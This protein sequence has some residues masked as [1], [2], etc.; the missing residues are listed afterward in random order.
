[1]P[2][3][4]RGRVAHMTQEA[5]SKPGALTR[6]GF[7]GVAA[8]AAGGVFWPHRAVIA[9]SNDLRMPP[10]R[11]PSRAVQMHSEE[12]VVGRAVHK[13][14]V[15]EMF[16]RSL[17]ALTDKREMAS[18]WR[19]ILRPDD[20]VGLKFN[21]SGQRNLGTS[22]VMGE[23]LI[24][25]LVDAGWPAEKL[26]CLEAPA[27]LETTA[28]TTVAVR[29]FRPEPTDFGSGRDQLARFV[30]QVTAIINVPFLKTHNIAGMT[31]SLKNL[32]H[33]LVKHPARY[34]ENGCSPFIADIVA[35]TEI[36]EKLRL[37]VVDALRV[38]FDKGPEATAETTYDR[39]TLLV[40]RDPVAADLVGLTLLNELR[41]EKGLPPVSKSAEDLPYLAEAHRRGIGIAV[42]HGVDLQR[43]TV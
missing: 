34:H 11:E 19:T 36:G 14:L 12:V 22:V 38:V 17:L 42:W 26:V 43:L 41:K 5:S 40:S 25:S 6:R 27:G 8:T 21:R 30:D 35:R 4:S 39:G 29:G 13:Q 16:E 33:G 10:G 37:N 18:A 20:T 15:G 24:A 9:A 32:S 28:G 3:H 7:L 2:T 23:V 31:C 1:M